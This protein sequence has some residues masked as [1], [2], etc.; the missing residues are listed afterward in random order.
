MIGSLVWTAL[1]H[2]VL[3]FA[4]IAVKQCQAMWRPLAMPLIIVPSTFE[5]LIVP[6]LPEVETVVRDIR[7]ALVSRTI[8]SVRRSKLALRSAWSAQWKK[9]LLGQRIVE[10]RRHG[11]WIFM[12]LANGRIV[13][14]HLGM[15]G[16]LTV[17][18]E[19]SPVADHTHFVLGLE[20]TGMQLRFRDTRRFGM[21][22]LLDPYGTIGEYLEKLGL[23]PEPFHVNADY[24]CGQLGK[25]RRSLKAILLDQRV[26]AGVGNIYADE[27]CF[28]AKLH[29]GRTGISLTTGEVR[30][31]AEA[32]PSVLHRAIDKR[33][34]T[35]RDYVGG[36]GLRGGFQD[37]F[38][39]YGRTGLPCV[40]CGKSILHLR[41]AGRA[42]HYCPRC[43]K[44]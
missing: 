33:G 9:V 3:G 26:V 6:E 21:V 22:A 34:S 2:I 30:R 27:S 16:Q 23:G 8:S 40:R 29:P 1:L 15:T 39:V 4:R 7:P 12:P 17:V 43:Q 42:T 19:A 31:L 14:I 18:P 37:E 36:S 13:V 20:D 24:W 41:L 5:G 28:A 32:V 10:V 44:A 38:C 11:K 35:I 25:T